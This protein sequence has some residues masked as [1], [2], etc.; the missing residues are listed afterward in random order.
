MAGRI[1]GGLKGVKITIR[2]TD[3]SRAVTR[4][5]RPRVQKAIEITAKEIATE[6]RRELRQGAG[7]G[8][9]YP[10]IASRRL[11]NSIKPGKASYSESGGRR[12][13]KAEVLVGASYA[14]AFS[15]GRP[16]GTAPRKN[17]IIAWAQAKFKNQ[18]EEAASLAARVAAKI[19]RR[20]IKAR[21]FLRN[22]TLRMQNKFITRIRR[23][24]KGGG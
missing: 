1:T 18:Y 7:E 11:L 6:A 13:F 10:N 20:G 2:P 5:I 15:R 4:A 22:A 16:A 3:L 23:S 12:T 8:D 17:S 9:K 21:P 14:R 24:L 19:R